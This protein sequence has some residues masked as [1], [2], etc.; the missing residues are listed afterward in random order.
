MYIYCNIYHNFHRQEGANKYV[1]NRNG[2]W[3]NNTKWETIDTCILAIFLGLKPAMPERGRSLFWW[4]CYVAAT[5]PALYLF[6]KVGSTCSQKYIHTYIHTLHTYIHTWTRGW[7]WRGARNSP[8]RTLRRS[9]PLY[10]ASSLEGCQ[11]LGDRTGRVPCMQKNMQS[12]RGDWHPRHW[13][14]LQEGF[15]NEQLPEPCQVH[16]YI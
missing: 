3:N 2:F 5:V 15:Q 14:F 7:Y 9:G 10:I 8:W 12:W 11:C 6:W 16:M 1:M 4:P 13:A